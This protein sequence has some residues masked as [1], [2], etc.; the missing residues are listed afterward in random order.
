MGDKKI[1]C[2]GLVCLD[3]I[4][5]V[6][7]YPEE[8]TDSR[9][10]SQRWQRGGNASNSCTVL[11]ILGAPCAFMGSLAPGPVA[12]FVLA[13]FLKYKIDVS[14]LAEWA[15]CSFPAS[16]V[17]SNVMTGSRTIL[18]MNSF[19]AGDFSHRGVDFSGVVWQ[20][21]GETPC[22]C[23]VV[24]PSSGSRTVVLFDTNLPDVSAEDFSR[25][26]LSQY[27]WI[28]W[29][30]RNAEEQVKMI[31]RVVQYNGEQPEE[32]RIT[33]S[34][35]IEKTREPLYQLFPHGDVV[36]V[37]KDVA[38]H[39]GF[40]TAADALRGLYC[41]VKKGAVLICAWAE[42]GA[43]AMGP[44]GKIVHADAFPPEALVDTLGAGDTFNASVIFSLSN[45][46]SLQEALT[47]GC[48]VAG[49]KCGVHGYDDILP[50]KH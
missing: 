4:N 12:D 2:I 38:R 36:F 41:K 10:L 44:D 7:R 6:D 5:V 39:F 17:I 16:M 28:H 47:F 27:K 18:H 19:I 50:P 43:D 48:Q 25:V 21:E 1:L 45:G 11:S 3:I 15:E 32:R 22:A 40:Q 29:E 23:C 33:I 46:K 37:S 42:K 14:L 24:C 35:E 8:D 49:R 34:V 9:C 31:Q 26:D 30:G 20:S 13:D